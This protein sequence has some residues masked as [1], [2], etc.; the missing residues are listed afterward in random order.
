MTVAEIKTTFKSIDAALVAIEHALFP[1]RF[2]TAY[3]VR[4]H[5]KRLRAWLTS[6]GYCVNGLHHG[7]ATHG[8]RCKHCYEV[9][10]K[11]QHKESST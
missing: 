11:Q 8:V 10:S 9:H 4:R 6:L 1:R 7:D 3:H 5:H 2:K